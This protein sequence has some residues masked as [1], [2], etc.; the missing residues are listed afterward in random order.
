MKVYIAG[1]DVFK[2]DAYSY[3]RD[4][5]ECCESYGVTALVP[6][7]ND[8]DDSEEIYK[9]NIELIDECDVIIAH[10]C[11][12][13]G[14]EPDSG[15]VFEVGYGKALGKKV[16]GYCNDFNLEYKDFII[17]DKKFSFVEDFGNRFNL[18]IQH[19]LDGL[20]QTFVETVE[21]IIKA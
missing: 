20:Y 6:I 1:P 15:T 5:K 3:F 17:P 12:F 19:S 9:K 2:E 16:Y 13:R 14:S 8:L 18:M 7:D 11:D 4:I 10:L 21:H